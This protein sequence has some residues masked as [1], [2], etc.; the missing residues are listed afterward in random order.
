MPEFRAFSSLLL[1]PM[2]YIRHFNVPHLNRR[3]E[4]E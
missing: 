4:R 2:W 1:D 3:D